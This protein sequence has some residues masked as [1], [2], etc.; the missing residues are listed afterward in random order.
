MTR[1]WG[2]ELLR[3]ELLMMCMPPDA[4]GPALARRFVAHSLTLLGMEEREPDA[5]LVV[6]ELVGN[7]CRYA[8]ER[9]TVRMES[10]D[11]EAL[12]FEIEDDGPG[13]P[14]VSDASPSA[15]SG[16]GLLIVSSI[17]RRWGTEPTPGG[18]VVWAELDVAR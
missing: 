3:P 14:C 6:S 10:E 4:E 7:A 11:S 5:A 9:V 13:E 12:R 17:A 2:D 8:N 15:T 18:K 16:R 1:L